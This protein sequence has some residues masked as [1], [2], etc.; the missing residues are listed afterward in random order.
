MPKVKDLMTP[1][2]MT[3]EPEMTLREALEE[4]VASGVSGAPV[5]SGGQRIAG[6]VSATDILEFQA[7]T[8]GIPARR[9]GGPEE[10]G[11]EDTFQAD[12]ATDPPAAYFVHMWDDSESDVLARVSDAEGPEWDVLQEHTVSEAMTRRVISVGADDDATHAARVMVRTGAHR[13]LVVDAAGAL[14]GIVSTMDIVRAVA[15]GRIGG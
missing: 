13:V 2:V 7:A 4:L 1:E 9:G 8:P 6:V 14:E 10:P 12:D 3:L 15:D 5:V 11:D